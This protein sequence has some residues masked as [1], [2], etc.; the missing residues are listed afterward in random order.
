VISFQLFGDLSPS[1]ERGR[2]RPLFRFFFLVLGRYR[3][4]ESS[5]RARGDLTCVEEGFYW[6]LE[7]CHSQLEDRPA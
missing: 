6:C 2:V 5:R 4:E 1:M 7:G 3:E